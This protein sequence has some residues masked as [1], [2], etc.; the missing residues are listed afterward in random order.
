MFQYIQLAD[1]SFQDASSDEN[2]EHKNK[3]FEHGDI[4]D[5]FYK[6]FH[7]LQLNAVHK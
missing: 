4:S 2:A 7:K 5:L 6:S 1:F 3:V